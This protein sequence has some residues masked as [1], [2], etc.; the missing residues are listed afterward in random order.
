MSVRYCISTGSLAEYSFSIWPVTTLESVL[1]KHV[2]TPRARNLRSPRMTA[3]YS[4]TLFVHLSDSSVKLRR[5]TYLY[6][7]LAGDVIIA[8]APAPVLHHAPS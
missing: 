4:A 6:L 3:S 1:M 5:T 2:V 7:T 8:A